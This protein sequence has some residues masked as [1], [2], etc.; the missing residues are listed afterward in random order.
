MDKKLCTISNSG[1]IPELGGIRGPI[2][3]PTE[4]SMTLIRTLI[5]EG[6]TIYEVNPMNRNEKVRLTF[7]NV[8][9][10]NF[11]KK[12]KK[13]QSV[14]VNPFQFPDGKQNT[15]DGRVV[16]KSNNGTKMKEE[17]AKEKTNDSSTQKLTRSDF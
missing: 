9:S 7:S 2:T 11:Y 1:P 4:L 17:K 8:N 13:A 14:T 3:K 5:N 16:E 6:Y 15:R 10:V 12:V